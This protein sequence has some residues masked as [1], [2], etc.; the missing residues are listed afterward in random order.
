MDCLNKTS[1]VFDRCFKDKISKIKETGIHL[2]LDT[3]DIQYLL[4]FQEE[5]RQY[6]KAHYPE[7]VR[8]MPETF[9]TFLCLVVDITHYTSWDD[10][11]IPCLYTK[12]P[13]LYDEVRDCS[14]C[15]GHSVQSSN[16]T[17]VECNGLYLALGDVCIYK[18]GVVHESDNL[19]RK[20]KNLK[21]EIPLPSKKFKLKFDDVKEELWFKMH[22]TCGR[23]CRDNI[24]GDCIKKEEEHQQRFEEYRIRAEEQAEEQ[25]QIIE[26]RR[27]RAEEQA[28]KIAES[29][30]ICG[31]YCPTF[32]HC[33]HCKMDTQDKCKC[34]KYKLKKFSKCYGC[35][36]S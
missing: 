26:E 19:L 34:G 28:K 17:I 36:K 21:K 27:I 23:F 29:C 8:R 35:N 20:K 14:C 13:Y 33:W 32:K 5:I 11:D 24:C 25:R 10:F 30:A 2:K 15:C 3:Y 9:A 6:L 1:I 18:Y 31:K 7:L 16:T 12:I 4:Y 22:C